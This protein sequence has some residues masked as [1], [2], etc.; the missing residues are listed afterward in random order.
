MWCLVR[1]LPSLIGHLVPEGCRIWAFYCILR[2][3][4]DMV[5]SLKASESQ[6]YYVEALIT[7]HHALLLQLWPEQTLTPKSHILLHYGEA[8]RRNGPLRL[9]WCMR[10][11]AKHQIAKRVGDL[12]NNYRNPC[13]TVANQYQVSA[14]SVWSL[15]KI[16]PET[17]AGPTMDDGSLAWVT[18]KGV[19]Y[20]PN[21][22]VHTGSTFDLPDLAHVVGVTLE[23]N[24]DYFLRCRKLN[25]HY[26]DTHMMAFI[27][28]HTRTNLSIRVNAL[29][30]PH[31]TYVTTTPCGLT[32]VIPRYSLT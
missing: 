12:T 15:N 31:I 25:V 14:F 29:A 4:V 9:L 26:F 7:D 2:E 28:S 21:C 19:D 27:V 32:V 17:G 5:F 11:E 8:M 22:V 10:F 30:S 16:H 24:G 23:V 13:L 3:I 18:Y 1:I 6:S 20:R